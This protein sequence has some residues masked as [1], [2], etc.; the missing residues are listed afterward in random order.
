MV[1]FSTMPASLASGA[2]ELDLR[3]LAQRRYPAL[4]LLSSGS[5]ML[6]VLLLAALLAALAITGV[7]CGWRWQLRLALYAVWACAL[8]LVIAANLPPR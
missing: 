6:P 3:V 1:R 5:A 8:Y 7:L 2:D 4:A